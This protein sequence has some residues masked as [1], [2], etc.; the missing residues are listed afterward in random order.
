MRPVQ[1][2][3]DQV[4]GNADLSW[5]NRELGRRKPSGILDLRV[6]ERDLTAFILSGESDHE[7]VGEGP[8]LTAEIFNPPDGDP[9]LL[10]N[11]SHDRL[12]QRFTGFYKTR[13]DTVDARRKVTRPRE[14]NLIAPHDTDDDGRGQARKMEQAAPGT[15]LCSLRRLREDRAPAAAAKLVGSIPIHDLDGPGSHP[16]E[17]LVKTTVELT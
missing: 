17:V 8:W 7:R 2:S 13:D 12:L 11:L 6:G 15:D 1:E 5:Q 16:E 9:D 4:S 10:S 3:V 14:E